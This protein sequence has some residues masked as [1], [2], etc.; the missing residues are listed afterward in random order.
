MSEF[1]LYKGL[2]LYTPKEVGK[3]DILIYAD[4]IVKIAE[5]IEPPFAAETDIKDY[6]GFLCFPGFVDGHVH[7]IGGG[8]EGG[9]FT[10]TTPQCEMDFFKSGTTAVIGVLGTDGITRTHR[11][12]LGQAR[13]FTHNHLKTFLMSGSYA[14]P[15]VTLLNDLQDDIVFIPEYIGIGEI[16]ISDHRGSGITIDEFRRLLLNTRVAGM[17]SG[18]AGKAII[19]V[20]A[21]KTGLQLLREA[22]SLG[23]IS[24]HQ[25]LP[26][27]INRT[28]RTL[29]EGKDWIENYGGFI[30]FTAGE[31]S[32]EGINTF[33]NENVPV[34][35]ILCSS[36]GWGSIPVFDEKGDFISVKTAPVDTLYKVFKN[37]VIDNNHPIE[38]SLKIFTSN[39]ADFFGVSKEG[40]GYIRENGVASFV[41]A[42]GSLKIK[43][44]CS[45]GKT[46]FQQ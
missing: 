29:Q 45:Q 31:K 3:K 7:I 36:D 44:T 43:E 41:I 34:E 25:M 39:V 40:Y 2:Q 18:K 10:R 14:L 12:L 20:G 24:P 1:K 13:K 26:T 5:T 42:D 6:S 30:D 37:L 28:A 38:K 27:H 22:I 8:G 46:V 35:N 23:D 15:L 4:K 19:H 16:A 11:D 17:L 32:I 21:V 33:L 9:F